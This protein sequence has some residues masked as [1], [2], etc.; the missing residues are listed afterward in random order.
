[1]L[2]N[3]VLPKLG[4]FFVCICVCILEQFQLL[5]YRIG[6]FL[7]LPEENFHAAELLVGDAQDSDTAR[8]WKVH[9]YATYMHIGIFAARAMPDVYR[10]LEHCKPIGNEFLAE[11]SVHFAFF[12]G[13]GWKVEEN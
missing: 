12:L 6:A 13:F 4:G 10:E 1:M 9:L 8:F 5:N 11:I 2:E 7:L 3:L